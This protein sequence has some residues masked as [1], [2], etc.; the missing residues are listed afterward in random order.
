MRNL[1]AVLMLLAL[2]VLAGSCGMGDACD[3]YENDVCDCSGGGPQACD[4]ARNR[5]KLLQETE[6]DPTFKCAELRR[7]Y[8]CPETK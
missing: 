8:R 1:S 5:V 4:D 7:D 3:E 6:K 2:S